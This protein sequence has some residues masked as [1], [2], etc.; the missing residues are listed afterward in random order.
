MDRGTAYPYPCGQCGTKFSSEAKLNSHTIVHTHH[1]T[2]EKENGTLYD[3]FVNNENFVYF[4][5]QCDH[6]TD[7]DDSLTNHKKEEHK[8]II[9]LS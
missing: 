6:R 8:I 2:E 1:E 3:E 4:C 7:C 5:D 9:D